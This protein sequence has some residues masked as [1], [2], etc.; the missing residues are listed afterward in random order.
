LKRL[1]SLLIVAILAVGT[2]A[3]TAI[4]SIYD[5]VFLRPPPYPAPHE[6]VSLRLVAA[7]GVLG[8]VGALGIVNWLTHTAPEVLAGA[9]PQV[10]LRFFVLTLAIVLA[11][12]LG[13]LVASVPSAR[14]RSVALTPGRGSGCGPQR[15]RLDRALVIAQLAIAVALAAAA[16]TVLRTARELAAIDTGLGNRSAVLFDATPPEEVY[17]RVEGLLRYVAQAEDAGRQWGGGAVVGATSVALGNN[18]PVLALSLSDPSGPERHQSPIRTAVS[19]RYF[20]ALG[21][22]LLAGRSFTDADLRRTDLLILSASAAAS[23]GARPAEVVG[24]HLTVG[25]T[26]EDRSRVA[27]V[28]GV[29]GDVRIFGPAFPTAI[30]YVPLGAEDYRPTVLTL[31]VSGVAAP[32]AAAGI[33]AI[34]A[35]ADPQVPAFNV[36]TPDDAAG[37]SLAHERVTLAATG[38]F[39]AAALL[40]AVLGV[41]GVLRRLVEARRREFAI[42]LAL[43]APAAHVRGLVL[44]QSAVLTGA[45]LIAG[46]LLSWWLWRAGSSLLPTL[47]PPSPAEPLAVAV[48]LV[49]VAL[50]SALL[51]AHAA[52]RV[53]P[54]AALKS[55]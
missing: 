27:E 6:I 52:T 45:G 9:A 36:T 13:S 44:V 22:P 33:Q 31:V 42:R 17:P 14:S 54:I 24:R 39:S 37:R 21:I 46:A 15:G 12:G 48:L 40:M 34:A 49:I 43:G 3:A 19:R 50:A 41:H 7:G 35:A 55:E 5:R 30:A 4:F 20:D 38:L 23:F 29:V 18:R 11:A 47:R 1:D 10:D 32:E 2:A 26:R 16:A 28:I 51:P 8:F 53:D 25:R